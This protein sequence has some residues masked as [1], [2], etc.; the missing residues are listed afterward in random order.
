MAA[1]RA[2][3]SWTPT[4]FPFWFFPAAAIVTWAP[5]IEPIRVFEFPRRIA[6]PVLAA[7]SIALIALLI[8]AVALPYLA[9][10]GYYATQA[11][12]DSQQARALIGQA[13][14]F[15]PYESLHATEAGMFA[16][17]A[18]PSPD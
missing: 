9:D 17:N 14:Q 13:P 10:A 5:R 11:T 16:L 2:V 4:A 6:V 7:G 12:A 15:P 3:S 8:P 18:D 1:L